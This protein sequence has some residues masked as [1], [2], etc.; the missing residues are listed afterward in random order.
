MTYSDSSIKNAEPKEKTLIL[1]LWHGNSLLDVK[2]ESGVAEMEFKFS[3]HHEPS[4]ELLN[5][6]LDLLHSWEQ[7]LWEPTKQFV[8]GFC[9]LELGDQPMSR[10]KTQTYMSNVWCCNFNRRL[11]IP[12]KV[13][14]R[15]DSCSIQ[16]QFDCL[17]SDN[18]SIFT[19]PQYE[20]YALVGTQSSA[21]EE[22]EFI[23]KAL[24]SATAELANLFGA[25]LLKSGTKIS[26]GKTTAPADPT[27]PDDCY[28]TR[29]VVVN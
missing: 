19:C 10:L 22:S 25:V 3:I 17:V 18:F 15:W 12:P 26:L 14:N 29:G 8:L 11:P 4:S 7:P 20:N 27:D 5:E 1:T 21:A 16:L 9:G 2:L 13:L 23:D 24:A 28:V 6:A